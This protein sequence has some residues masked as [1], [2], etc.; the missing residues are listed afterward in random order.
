MQP[1][2]RIYLEQLAKMA[3]LTAQEMSAAMRV[4]LREEWLFEPMIQDHL[5]VE[6][7]KLLLLLGQ[8]TE[9]AFDDNKGLKDFFGKQLEPHVHLGSEYKKRSRYLAS[10]L[11]K[12]AMAI[13][14]LIY[15]TELDKKAR[16]AK[17]VS[18]K[19]F[20]IDPELLIDLNPQQAADFLAIFQQHFSSTTPE[21]DLETLEALF[22]TQVLPVF[23]QHAGQSM[24][25][26]GAELNINELPA[27]LQKL[28][29]I[30]LLWPLE[31][32]DQPLYS[33][34]IAT[35]AEF[36]GRLTKDLEKTFFSRVLSYK[37]ATQ[38]ALDAL[39]QL[40]GSHYKSRDNRT[41]YMR[42]ALSVVEFA[43]DYVPTLSVAKRSF[44][45]FRKHATQ[46]AS[47][48]QTQ[49]LEK[50]FGLHHLIPVPSNQPLLNIC[51]DGF[52]SEASKEQFC[53]WQSGFEQ[54]PTLTGGLAGFAWPARNLVAANLSF[55]YEAVDNAATYGQRLA[56][57]IKFMHATNPQL[58]LRL[59]GH[60]L[61]SRVIY[62][63]L[64]E[65]IGSGCKV[66]EV[67]LLGGAV[68][69]KDRQ[70]WG[71]ALQ[72]V[73]RRVV[74]CYSHNDQVLQKLYRTA[75][76]GDEPIGLGELEF[77]DTKGSQQAEVVNI[78]ASSI[79]TGHNDYKPKLQAV[80]EQV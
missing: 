19:L 46:L 77:F 26:P 63:A 75:Q 13:Y 17:P 5:G 44:S 71:G 80:I 64:I 29:L 53:D 38:E 72:S 10:T 30:L 32:T 54:L 70:G 28:L 76:L 49:G 51:I 25:A 40:D 59:L 56:H 16:Q 45:Q 18:T 48:Q 1:Q 7:Q 31:A 8:L 3:D 66:E 39:R 36:F 52:L 57:D 78:N 9:L 4:D 27:W 33:A 23:E 41:H 62:H 42:K 20:L 61:G 12:G 21:D 35:L 6:A 22:I 2:A 58:R 65:L 69:R 14:D 47:Q 50:T 34:K 60:S 55:W 15:A 73:T 68:S 79:I 67:Y 43:T 37:Q 24:P 74:N 11:C